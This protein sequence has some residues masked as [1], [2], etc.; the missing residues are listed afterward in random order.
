MELNGTTR[1]A[2]Y[3]GIDVTGALAYGGG[4]TIEVG[5]AFL[6]SSENFSLLTFDSQSGNLESVNL[7]GAY[8]SGSFNNSG[9]I[10][11]L[12][13]SGGNQWSFS[14]TTG[15]LGFTAV[16]EPSTLALIVLV[17]VGILV[18]RLKVQR[19]A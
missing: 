7:A 4:L 5:S 8:G 13:D 9:G 3:D 16:P 19:K 1:G 14:E 15:N 17:F 12:T 10:W 2:Q 6:G 18:A 11:S